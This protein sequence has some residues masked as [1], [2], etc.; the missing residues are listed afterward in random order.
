MGMKFTANVKVGIT[1]ELDG[2]I[3]QLCEMFECKKTVLVRSLLWKVDDIIGEAN[4]DDIDV[5][6]FIEI[7][8]G[9]ERLVR[10]ILTT[11]NGV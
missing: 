5:E 9:K 10:R 4:T 11:K 2:K 3:N 1:E 6:Y 7:K 8:K